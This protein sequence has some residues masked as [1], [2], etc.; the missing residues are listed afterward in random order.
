MLARC[1]LGLLLLQAAVLGFGGFE[2]TSEDGT[3]YYIDEV[4]E[5]DRPDLEANGCDVDCVETCWYLA[6]GNTFISCVDF[7]GCE[8]LITEK[9]ET[10]A[11]QSDSSKD[12]K[13]EHRSGPPKDPDDE[14][15]L[16][17]KRNRA[18][19]TATHMQVDEHQYAIQAHKAWK[20]QIPAHKT[21]KSTLRGSGNLRSSKPEEPEAEA[22]VAYSDCSSECSY[23]CSKSAENCL[24]K[25]KAS[26]CV[27]GGWSISEYLSSAVFLGAA[28]MAISYIIRKFMPKKKAGY[29]LE[30][31]THRD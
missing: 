23:I 4:F 16:R 21:W 31:S 20:T 29:L 9:E 7:C 17:S 10:S 3:V 15:V 1:A 8:E 26:F 22:T 18:S 14:I 12:A 11:E 24:D 19:E 28:A 25:C 13:K 27:S 2:F 30:D 5:E 6:D